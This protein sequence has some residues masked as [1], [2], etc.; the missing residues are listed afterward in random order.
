[1]SM[2]QKEAVELLECKERTFAWIIEDR[3]VPVRDFSPGKGTA[4]QLSFREVVNIGIAVRLH[5]SGMRPH[6]IR[7]L[8]GERE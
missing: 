5:E 1:M 3:I 6:L 7:H 2:T 4:R 8:M